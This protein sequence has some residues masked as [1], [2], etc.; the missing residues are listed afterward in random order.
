[1]QGDL[2]KKYF[3]LYPAWSQNHFEYCLPTMHFTF[4]VPN[5][6]YKSLTDLCDRNTF[7]SQCPLIDLSDF[8]IKLLNGYIQSLLTWDIVLDDSN[9]LCVIFFFLKKAVVQFFLRFFQSQ[10][11]YLY[12]SY[13]IYEIIFVHS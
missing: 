11:V 13:C 1:M 10:H 3:H 7:L 6:V 2:S 5:N 9:G 8:S 12:G 4:P